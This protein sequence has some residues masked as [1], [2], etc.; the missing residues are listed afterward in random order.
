MSPHAAVEGILPVFKALLGTCLA[1]AWRGAERNPARRCASAAPRSKNG[2]NVEAGVF[3]A[4]KSGV[5]TGVKVNW[6]ASKS[7]CSFAAATKYS[8]DANSFVKAKVNDK[9]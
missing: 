2:S 3:H 8:L 5:Q 4:P 1:R 7:A 9:L 6:D